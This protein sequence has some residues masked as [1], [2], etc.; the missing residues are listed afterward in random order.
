M[1]NSSVHD[2]YVTALDE[3]RIAADP[4]QAALVEK[5]DRLADE[6]NG[7]RLPARGLF[8]RLFGAKPTPRGL[9]VHGEVGRGKSFLMDMFF[10]SADVTPKRRVHFHAFMADVHARVHAWR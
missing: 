3:A 2:A 10:D 1:V 5:L 8:G 4:A 6:L 9:Y 7:Y